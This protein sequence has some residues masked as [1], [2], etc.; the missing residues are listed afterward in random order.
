[1]K[2]FILNTAN[3]LPLLW[4]ASLLAATSLQAE[5][6][7]LIGDNALG[8]S[9]ETGDDWSDGQPAGPGK[10][11]LIDGDFSMRSPDGAE[12]D[13]FPGDSL[14]VNTA[15][16]GK[17]I[18]FKASADKTITFNDLQ[19]GGGRLNLASD[20]DFTLAGGLNV[21]EGQGGGTQV[22]GSGDRSLTIASEV[23]GGSRIKV[24][25]LKKKLKDTHRNIRITL[26]PEVSE[27]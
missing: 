23:S 18:G 21:F 27:H 11:Y 2:V 24:K 3:R 8:Q 16:S 14:T 12:D 4:T 5:L 6:V 17:G 25:K 13:V 9:W 10:D 7:T 15:R 1:M 26:T 22:S 20:S 19:W